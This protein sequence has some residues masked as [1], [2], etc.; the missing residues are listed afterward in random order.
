MITLLLYLLSLSI[1]QSMPALRLGAD[2]T[3][4]DLFIRYNYDNSNYML[5]FNPNKDATI[6]TLCFRFKPIID[7]LDG[8][9]KLGNI[10]GNFDC[11]GADT[12]DAIT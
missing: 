1:Q 3:R 7:N 8:T 2:A 10:T 11:Y 4:N 12:G 5:Q 6:L 9:C